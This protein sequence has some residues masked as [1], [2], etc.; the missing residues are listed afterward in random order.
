MEYFDQ[1]IPFVEIKLIM[2]VIEYSGKQ[3]NI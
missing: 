2:S 1:V 3:Y